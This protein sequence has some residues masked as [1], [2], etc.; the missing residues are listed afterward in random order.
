MAEEIQQ[1]AAIDE[2]RARDIERINMV[3]ASVSEWLLTLL[4]ATSAQ[5][6][7]GDVLIA[8]AEAGIAAQRPLQVDTG[9]NTLIEERACAVLTVRLPNHA[10]RKTYALRLAVCAEAQ[11]TL[12]ANHTNYLG[13]PGNPRMAV[14]PFYSEFFEHQPH[15]TNEAGYIFGE[16]TKFGVP[17]P[18]PITSAAPYYPDLISHSYEDGSM[19]I[20]RFNTADWPAAQTDIVKTVREV[21]SRVMQRIEQDNQ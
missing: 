20:A 13:V 1:K 10:R 12:P 17:A 6:S 9:N 21:L 3:N 15:L 19:A 2:T 14:L 18:I 5:I 8:S 4:K 16:A 7:A 11:H